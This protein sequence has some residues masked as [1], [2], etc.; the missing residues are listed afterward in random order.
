MTGI[1]SISFVVFVLINVVA[2]LMEK[3][4][5]VRVRV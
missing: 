1:T 4:E 2:V 3:L 5:G